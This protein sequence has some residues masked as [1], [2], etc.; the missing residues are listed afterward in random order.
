MATKRHASD[1]ARVVS[2]FG[3][4]SD[5]VENISVIDALRLQQMLRM[6]EFQAGIISGI[7]A[8]VEDD[9]E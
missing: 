3:P 7:A 6:L 2:L 9:C 1:L 8:A 5:H 4:P